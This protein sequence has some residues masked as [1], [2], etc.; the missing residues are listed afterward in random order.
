MKLTLATAPTVE[1]ATLTEAK[2]HLRVDGTDEDNLITDL[3]KASRAWC[4]HQSGRAFLEQTWRM[5]LDEFPDEDQIVLPRPRL[6]SITTIKYYDISGVQQ[7]MS[8]TLY[9]VDTEDEPGA[10]YPAP[11]TTWPDTQSGRINAVEIVYVAK[12]AASAAALDPR[13]KQAVLLLVAH[14]YQNREDA[15]VGTISKEVEHAARELMRQIW[16][17]HLF[18]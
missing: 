18:G 9:Q 4:E 15:L 14:W 17:G 1:P 12:C 16:H 3:I 2:L 5:S 13:I 11:N 7:T 10:V 8:S 6:A